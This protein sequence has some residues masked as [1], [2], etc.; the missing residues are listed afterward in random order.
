MTD[1]SSADPVDDGREIRQDPVDGS[2][3]VAVAAWQGETLSPLVERGSER[4]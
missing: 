1:V 3:E 2:L 4:R